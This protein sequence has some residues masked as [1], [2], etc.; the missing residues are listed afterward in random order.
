MWNYIIEDFLVKELK[1]WAVS[2]DTCFHFC[3]LDISILLLTLYVDDLLI[4]GSSMNQVSCTKGKLRRR[5]EM[6]TWVK[7][8]SALAKFVEIESP[9]HCSRLNTAIFRKF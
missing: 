6:K 4:A 3:V 8:T 2:A 5:F 7:R 1:F 9:E